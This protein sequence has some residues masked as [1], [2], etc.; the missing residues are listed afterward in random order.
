VTYQEWVAAFRTVHA[1]PSAC[2]P[3]QRNPWGKNYGLDQEAEIVLAPA[4]SS[5]L[6]FP[7]VHRLVRGIGIYSVF[8]RYQAGHRQQFW[9]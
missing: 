8:Q 3:Y 7:R 5:Q 4:A 6:L 1:I 9:H 2:C